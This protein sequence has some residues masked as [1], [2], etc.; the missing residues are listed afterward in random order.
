MTP[1]VLNVLKLYGVVNNELSQ[2]QY[3]KEVLNLYYAL[4]QVA[5]MSHGISN[6]TWVQTAQGHL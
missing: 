6:D 1:P 3:T 2:E 5:E 4:T